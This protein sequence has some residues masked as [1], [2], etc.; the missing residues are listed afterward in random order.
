[1]NIGG[2]LLSPHDP[3]DYP[4]GSVA[5]VSAENIPAD[6]EVWQPPVENQG[7]VGN[8]VAQSCANI[9]ECIAHEYGEDHKDYSVGFIYGHPDNSS[10]DYGMY[11][12]DACKILQKSGDILRE[13]WDCLSYENPGC[14]AL[15]LKY[16]T[17][18]MK[19]Q[20]RKIAAYVRIHSKAEMQAFML[21]YN[22]PVMIIAKSEAFKEGVGGRHATVC[23]GWI[24]K[25]TYEKD[26]SRVNDRNETQEYEDLKFTNSWG[27]HNHV[28]N[29]RGFC[30]FE[31][32]EE[33][34]GLVPV[35]KVTLSDIKNNW[36]KK[37]IESLLNL[38]IIT[39]YPDNTF[40]P[41]KSITRAEAATMIMRQ[42]RRQDAINAEFNKRLK[43]IE[44][45][46]GIN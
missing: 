4:V 39:G 44:E 3:R 5:Q 9:M 8:C 11:P 2:A 1:M 27:T 33:I 13:V 25:E 19:S 26:P 29:G 37:D 23:Y 43:V 41:E 31:D 42:I 21:K 10:P 18:D 46:L 20:A 22:L 28:N 6:F 17:E 32:M 40:R 30:K 35:E 12:R 16:V 14:K 45:R 7:S 15:W 38:G 36:A 24:S 34:W